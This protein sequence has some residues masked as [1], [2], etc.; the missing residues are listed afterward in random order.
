[1]EE[2][3]GAWRFDE[4][5]YD[6]AERPFHHSLQPD[7]LKEGEERIYKN[8]ARASFQSSRNGTP[9]GSV[10]AGRASMDGGLAALSTTSP[11]PRQSVD[12][13]VGAVE[14]G[15]GD[16][17]N[18]TQVDIGKQADK[19]AIEGV[20]KDEPMPQH[21]RLRSKEEE[22]RSAVDGLSVKEKAAVEDMLRDLY[23]SGG[24]KR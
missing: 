19:K 3:K 13:R 15:K 4:E 21:V 23:V 5:A 18:G 9:R 14:D 7:N 11:R 16:D 6:K 22:L 20:P 10:D 2:T 1:M 8:G 24:R 12:H 17:V